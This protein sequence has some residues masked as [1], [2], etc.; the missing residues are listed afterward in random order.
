MELSKDSAAQVREDRTLV[1]RVLR[2]A[3]STVAPPV[4]ECG[5]GK[6]PQIRICS[7]HWVPSLPLFLSRPRDPLWIQSPVHVLKLLLALTHTV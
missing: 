6:S 1:P 5:L 7:V 3:R 4:S 2:G